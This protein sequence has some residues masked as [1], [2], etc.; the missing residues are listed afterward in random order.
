MLRLC[1]YIASAVCNSLPVYLVSADTQDSEQLLV[2]LAGAVH[3]SLSSPLSRPVVQ[4][5]LFTPLWPHLLVLFR[6]ANR[7]QET[8]LA[9]VLTRLGAAGSHPA[10]AQ[11][12]RLLLR[13]L[14]L[15]TSPADKCRLLVELVRALCD[16]ADGPAGAD[17]LLPRLT[18]LVVHSAAPQLLSELQFISEFMSDG[19][20]QGEQ[21]Y[22]LTTLQ[23][24]L[25]YLV[26]QQ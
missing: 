23:T 22:C 10:P 19:S 6:L 2:A 21:G 12:A 7:R 1:I 15:A 3:P 14:L 5:V 18:A 20:F 8:R 9:E 26:Q 16:T 4:R 11:P 13:R 25:L 24:A 17:V